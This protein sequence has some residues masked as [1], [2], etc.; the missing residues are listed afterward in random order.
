MKKGDTVKIYYDPITCKELEGKA[1]LIRKHKWNDVHLERWT[2]K[3]LH[4]FEDKADRFILKG[5]P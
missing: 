2:V 3:F 1:R 5:K 4:G